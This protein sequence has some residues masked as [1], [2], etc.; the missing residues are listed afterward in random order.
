MPVRVLEQT[1]HLIE[2]RPSRHDAQALGEAVEEPRHVPRQVKPLTR[3]PGQIRGRA[4]NASPPAQGTPGRWP[5]HPSQRDSHAGEAPQPTQS[6]RTLFLR[7]RRLNVAHIALRIVLPR[8]CFPKSLD[9]VLRGPAGS[10]PTPSRRPEPV[11]GPCS[12]PGRSVRRCA[13]SPVNGGPPLRR[14]S[15]APYGRCVPGPA[16]SRAV[17]ISS[18]G[19]VGRGDGPGAVRPHGGGCR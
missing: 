10:P 14:A 7:I 17:D 8:A 16:R 2:P 5:S 18:P 4:L 6:H 3:R 9:G 11:S 1:G 19:R 15:N 13:S 12:R